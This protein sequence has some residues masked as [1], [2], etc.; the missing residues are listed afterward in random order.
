MDCTHPL[1]QSRTN[2]SGKTTAK[3]TKTLVLTLTQ[4]SNKKCSQLL[5]LIIRIC[6]FNPRRPKSQK[7]MTMAIS[8]LICLL[9]QH[10]HQ[11]KNFIIIFSLGLP[12]PTEPAC[13]V[14]LTLLVP[15]PRQAHRK[16]QIGFVQI[17]KTII[18]LGL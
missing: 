2:K 10:S 5:A 12:L 9:S 8:C 17:V 7:Q 1:F 3:F 13:S 16:C 4:K 6:I 15:N 11:C 18:M 14:P